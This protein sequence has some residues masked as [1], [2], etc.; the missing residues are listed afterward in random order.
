[1]SETRDRAPAS[2]WLTKARV[3]FAVAAG[4]LLVAATG[5]NA[6]MGVLEWTMAKKPVPWPAVV[7]VDPVEQRLLNFPTEIGPYALPADGEMSAER[8]G[9]PDGIVTIRDEDLKTLGTKAHELNWYYSA[10]YVRTQPLPGEEGAALR[11][12]VRLDM[13]YYTGLLDAVPHVPDICLIQGGATLVPDASGPIRIT[14]PTVAAPWR[15]FDV[16]RT[17]YEMPKTRSQSAQFHFFSMNALPTARWERVRGELTLPWVK[18]CYFAKIQ[19]ATFR[20][21]SG[22]WQPETDLGKCEEVCKDFLRYALPEILR[23]LPS[24]EA[25]K[26][27]GASGTAN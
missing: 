2:R 13:T 17:A 22:Q 25:I 15:E 1:M 4:V 8:D 14:V 26:K 7:E 11:R 10:M 20:V 18:Y 23:Y 6:I 24:A 12:Y 19:L 21:E 9:K 5:W 3:H 16:Y 27:L